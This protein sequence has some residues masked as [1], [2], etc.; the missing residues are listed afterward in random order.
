MTW[1][2]EITPTAIPSLPQTTT[3]GVSRFARI[4]AASKSDA[5]GLSTASRFR[6][7]SKMFL[8]RI[9]SMVPHLLFVRG[10][11]LLCAL[12][13]P[14]RSPDTAIAPRMRQYEHGQRSAER[15]PGG[16]DRMYGGVHPRLLIR[17]SNE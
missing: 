16:V 11:P 14:S 3:R 10:S 17:Y 7:E 4:W 2:L 8:T 1:L 15:S 5:S 12:L 6:A 9:I 13:M